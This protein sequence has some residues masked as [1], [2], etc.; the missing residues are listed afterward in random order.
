MI[1]I[2]EYIEKLA[3]V[4]DLSKMHFPD[5]SD[6][7]FWQMYQDRILLIEGDIESWDYHIAKDIVQ[8][9]Y[10]DRC[11]PIEERK[12][13]I[14]LINSSGGKLHIMFNIVDAIKISKTPIWTVNMGEALSAACILFLMGEKRFC[15]PNSWAMCHDGSGGIQ[16]NYAE[17]K[18]M[19]KVWD[20]QV[21]DM[22]KLIIERTGMDKRTYNKNKDK[23]WWLNSEQQLKYGFATDMLTDIDIL[24]RE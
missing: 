3:T 15:L 19:A 23:D 2:T 14:L 20:E 18:E 21:D 6:Y 22:G 7:N 5:I 17:T 16:G 24:W 11:I 12:P 9:N 4:E 8:F 1:D 13:I 10:E